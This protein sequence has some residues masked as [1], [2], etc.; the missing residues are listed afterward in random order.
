MPNSTRSS[1]RFAPSRPRAK[2]LGGRVAWRPSRLLIAI[3]VAFALLAPL[4]VLASEMPRAAA[5][6]LAL[7]AFVSGLCN[8]YREAGRPACDIVIAA[9]DAASTID[10]RIARD[11][12]VTWRGPLAFLRWRDED[13][14]IRRLAFWP[15]T[16]PAGQRRELRLAAAGQEITRSRASVAP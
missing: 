6:P 14:R 15:D 2:G 7:A 16:L 4:A 5:W 8:A 9:G 10:G 12:I 3:L 1:N 13:G 11:L